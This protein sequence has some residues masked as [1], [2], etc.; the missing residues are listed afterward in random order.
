MGWIGTAL[1]FWL[2]LPA[3]SQP[4]REKQE[5]ER[6]ARAAAAAFRKA[7]DPQR[8]AVQNAAAFEKLKFEGRVIVHD[9]IFKELSKV[10]G[11]GPLIGRKVIELLRRV[12]H[13]RAEAILQDIAERYSFDKGIAE[14]MRELAQARSAVAS[15]RKAYE[16]ADSQGSQSEALAKLKGKDGRILLHDLVVDELIKVAGDGATV[17]IAVARSVRDQDH[18]GA[19]QVLAA[20]VRKYPEGWEVLGEVAEGLSVVQ[21]QDVFEA[22]GEILGNA[23]SGEGAPGLETASKVVLAAE[24]T[25]AVAMIEP[26]ANFLKS[27]EAAA[28]RSNGLPGSR[29]EELRTAVIAALE[30]CSGL[31]KVHNHA[32]FAAEWKERATSQMERARISVWCAATGRRFERKPE[33]PAECPHHAQGRPA[34][35]TL[36]IDALRIMR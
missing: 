2:A 14:E 20:I 26:L 10:L 29:L 31:E 11:D 22:M 6:R 32:S 15:F 27:L 13:P 1:L 16:K 34:K 36:H 28:E 23:L 18:P 9:L 5:I 33:D 8:P 35:E 17:A 24:R 19:A 21:W 4:A 3:D 7:Y 30:A 12:E 25:R